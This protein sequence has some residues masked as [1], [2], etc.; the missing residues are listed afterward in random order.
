MNSY[1]YQGNLFEG[2]VGF[3]DFEENEIKSLATDKREYKME[4][5]L[6]EFNL[7]TKELV[8]SLQFFVNSGAKTPVKATGFAACYDMSAHME[9]GKK[10]KIFNTH[11]KVTERQIQKNSEGNPF[12]NLGE[13]E[14][15]LIPTGVRTSMPENYS[16]RLHPRSG[17][18]IKNG[19]T[20]SN[21]EGVVDADYVN[22]IFI[23]IVN[24]SK[25]LFMIS[26]GIR[27]A[28]AEFVKEEKSL[29][30]LVIEN[31]N[32]SDL[33]KKTNR[34]GGFGSSGVK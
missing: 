9:L 3:S 10:I 16:L 25:E 2:T 5:G 22:E 23:P 4:G 8:N 7:E 17:L 33:E 28:Q 29:D 14:R 12:I 21:C 13:G 31:H 19:I 30:V 27:I 11:N 18:A 34:S 15:A 24:M 6:N 20:L 1:Q 26:D 32:G